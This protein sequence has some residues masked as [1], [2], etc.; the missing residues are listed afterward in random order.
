MSKIAERIFS[1]DGKVIIHQQHDFQRT[2]EAATAARNAG[3]GDLG[4]NKVVGRIP[5]KLA[6]IWA[7]EAGVAYGSEE[8]MSIIEKKML[9]GEFAKLRIWE[10]TF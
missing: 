9:D 4:E 6:A 7:K 2:V 3:L 10:G 8:H 1:Q 5:A